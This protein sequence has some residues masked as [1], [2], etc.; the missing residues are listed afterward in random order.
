M[1]CLVHHRRWSSLPPGHFYQMVPKDGLKDHER[2]P[3]PQPA[4]TLSFWQK[5]LQLYYAQR[6]IFLNLQAIGLLN[7]STES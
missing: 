6:Q 5:I 3:E 4:Y 7:N 1:I 2:R